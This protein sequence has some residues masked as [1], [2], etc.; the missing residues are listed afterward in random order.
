MYTFPLMNINEQATGG[1][2][3]RSRDR[4]GHPPLCAG[5]GFPVP[6]QCVQNTSTRQPSVCSHTTVSLHRQWAMPPPGECSGSDC[7]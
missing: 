2:G 5:K 1:I 3:M 7:A 6:L 4:S